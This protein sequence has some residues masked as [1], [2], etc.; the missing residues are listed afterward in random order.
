MAVLVVIIRMEPTGVAEVMFLQ[1]HQVLL[2]GA[3]AEVVVVLA[4]LQEMVMIVTGGTLYAA[5]HGEKVEMVRQVPTGLLAIATVQMTDQIVITPQRPI[6]S[7]M[8]NL[9]PELMEL[10]AVAA[11]VEAAVRKVQRVLVSA[12]LSLEVMVEMVELVELEVSA[13]LV[14]MA[15]VETSEHTS[16]IAQTLIFSTVQ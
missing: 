8:I 12:V 10:A 13:V 14:V 5:H 16:L 9:L 15:V 2:V 6:I 11:A 1:G 4:V 3:L 7:Q